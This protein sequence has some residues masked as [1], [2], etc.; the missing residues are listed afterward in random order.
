MEYMGM[1]RRTLAMML[2]CATTRLLV[3]AESAPNVVGQYRADYP[4]EIT[5]TLELEGDGAAKYAV[6]RLSSDGTQVL[7]H[8]SE[9]GRWV[10]QGTT[11]T[12][13]LP[14]D[15]KQG[16]IVYKISTC[17]RQ[18]ILIRPCSTGLVPVK[19]D[20]PTWYTWALLKIQDGKAKSAA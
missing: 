10:L 13:T 9:S 12:L 4:S 19:S 6:T 5:A 2:L 17:S 3:A 18:D 8:Y 11:L 15:A 16:T 7:Q 1:N 20:M 14:L